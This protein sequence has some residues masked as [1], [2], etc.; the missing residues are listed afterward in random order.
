MAYSTSGVLPVE[1]LPP[2]TSLLVSGP[3]LTRKRELMI[4]LL[5]GDTAEEVAM[6]TTKMGAGNLLEL[7]REWNGEWP[8][9]RL[10]VVDCVTRERGLGA[11]RETATTSYVSSPRD[12]TG[13]SIELSGLFKRIHADGRPMRFGIHSL[14]T[15]LMYHDLRRVYRMLHVLSGQIE[16]IGGVGV[17][18]VDSPTE[19]ERDILSQ[20]IDGIVETRE[21]ESGCELRLRGLGG[22]GAGWQ[23]Y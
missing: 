18:V 16:S 6:V 12:M 3:P 2:G 21:T 1:E 11:V 23:P 4:R 8:T 10:H 9:E 7:F 13:L 5:G 17:F 19:R 14:S 22:R 20:L 15:F